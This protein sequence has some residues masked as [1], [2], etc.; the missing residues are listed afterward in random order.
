MAGDMDFIGF[1]YNGKHSWRDLGIYRTSDGARYNEN[2]AASLNDKVTDVPGGDGQYY[3]YTRLKNKTFSL[4][5]AFDSLTE[6]GL[7][8]LKQVFDGTGIHDL[9][10]DEAPYKTWSA[11]IT[12][13]PTIKHL[14]FTDDEGNRVYKGE[15]SLT[16]TCY[17]PYARSSD[18]TGFEVR[19]SATRAPGRTWIDC[20]LFAEG[21]STLQYNCDFPVS[22]A[23]AERHGTEWKDKEIKVLD[24]P[25]ASYTFS[26]PIWIKQ[27]YIGGNTNAAS[28][29]LT[30]DNKEY[31]YTSNGVIEY[32][33]ESLDG[34]NI[35]HYALSKFPNKPEWAPASGML[36]KPGHGE[37]YGDLPTAFIYYKNNVSKDETIALTID[38]ITEAS[39]TSTTLAEIV[40]HEACQELKW[41][42]KTGLVTC[43]DRE[44]RR[45]V[46]YS[47]NSLATIPV[48]NNTLTNFN[49]TLTY[50]Y[51]YY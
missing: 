37:N 23:W 50:N 38:V 14:C 51:W 13:T 7:R 48:G 40:I 10:F 34:R 42:S 21:G 49:G 3:F 26:K 36:N 47:G 46:N 20:H 44:N 33:D 43:K 22:I 9:I 39:A 5:Y 27:I 1:T 17:W 41:D 45:P 12:G 24:D 19:E 30:L 4:S 6:S 29:T 31:N 18:L 16:F 15:G 25:K 35:N 28:I 8:Q 11:K 32:L 2:L